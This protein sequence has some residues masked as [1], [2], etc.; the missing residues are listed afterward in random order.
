MN[1]RRPPSFAK[2][3]RALASRAQ[4][5]AT[6]RPRAALPVFVAYADIP[7]ARHA[8]HRLSQWLRKNHRHAELRP[9]LWR[10]DQLDDPRWRDLSLRDAEST[11]TLVLA[12]RDETAVCAR[13][14]AWLAALLQRIRGTSIDVWTLIGETEG[15]TVTLSPPTASPAQASAIPAAPPREVFASVAAKRI[16]AC[17][18]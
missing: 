4:A 12:M 5:D 9:M 18:A 3:I 13:T 2:A 8:L 14:Q 17:A 15:W 11:R 7:S 16:T 1:A 10:F 6:Q